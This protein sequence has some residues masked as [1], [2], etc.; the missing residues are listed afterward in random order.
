MVAL[1]TKVR[2]LGPLPIWARPSPVGLRMADNAR[3]G[4]PA[5]LRFDHD[6]FMDEYIDVMQ[7]EPERLGE[8]IAQAE[9]WREPM[10]S[11]TRGQ[12]DAPAASRVAFLYD[13]THRLAK[14]KKPLLPTAVNL[15]PLKTQFKQK[16]LPA[17]AAISDEQLPLKLFQ[18]AQK[19]HYLVTA[20]LVCEQ[21]GL[22]DCQPELTRQEK[23]SFV[24]RRLLPPEGN[25]NAPLREWDEYA[26]VPGPKHNSW[27][28]IGHHHATITRSLVAGEEQLPMFPVTFAH[29]VCGDSRTLF[30][31]T[32]PVG[33]REQWVG[34]ELGADAAADNTI[35][36]GRSMAAMLFQTDVVAPWKLLLEQAEFKQNGANKTFANFGSD[37]TAQARERRRLLRTARDEL[38]TG[39][40]YVLLDF[41]RFLERHLPDVWQTLKGEKEFATLNDAEQALVTAINN[42]VLGGELGWEIIAGKP[43]AEAT[44]DA[45]RYL[46]QLLQFIAFWNEQTPG[47]INS[48]W[49]S[50]L[51]SIG[52]G[53]HIPSAAARYKFTALKWTLG[54]ALLAAADSAQGLEAVETT[55]IRFNESGAPISVNSQWPDFLF[56]LADP[57]RDAP[58]PAVSSAE[59]SGLS[60]LERKQSAVDVLAE[61]VEA[62]LPP[63]EPAAELMDTVPLGD[64]RASWFVLRCVYERP[65]CGPLFPA[66]VS[67]PTQQFQMAPFFDPDAPARPVRIP[68]PMDIS[69]AGLRKYQK[70]TGFVISDMLC[71]KIKGIRKMSFAD[72]VLSVLPWPFHKDLPDPGSGTCKEGGNSFGM[73]CSLSIPIVT[74]CALILM[75]IMVAL[76]DLF[77]RWIPYL[78]V[79]LPIPGLKGK[80][81]A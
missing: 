9:T 56:P 48:S 79:C 78:F 28:R 50:H 30:N 1:K 27:R 8:W 68:M 59:L 5:I 18:P 37:A 35:S 42:T 77:F 72:L 52:W 61:M 54:H 3:A 17:V 55:F 6:A 11:P 29:K 73:I 41:A 20:S 33:R 47:S 32:I 40:W 22:P 75:M 70:N 34:A 81:G 64:T 36:A 13:K 71:G 38:Q 39:S 16:A 58:M 45:E 31:G 80:K 24:V 46:L 26:F 62:L 10:A 66:L 2:W 12:A 69:P 4:Q 60:G 21:A 19:R 57:D 49:F 44:S 15:Q 25:P 51:L 67:A 14:A 74:L 65:H 43:A 63:G 7:S 76:F 53:A 23:V